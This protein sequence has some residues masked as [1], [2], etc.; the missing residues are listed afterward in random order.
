[1]GPRRGDDGSMVTLVA[2]LNPS[3]VA[4]FVGKLRC[5]LFKAYVCRRYST[6]WSVSWIWV[7]VWATATVFLVKRAL[8]EAQGF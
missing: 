7:V 6:G 4:S 2:F 5:P 1:L 3:E 8:G